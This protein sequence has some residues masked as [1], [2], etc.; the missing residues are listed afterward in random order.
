[1]VSPADRG[2]AATPASVAAVGANAE[3]HCASVRKSR[4]SG[5]PGVEMASTSC[6]AAASL[7]TPSTTW[8]STACELG[9]APRSVAVVAQAGRLPATEVLPLTPAALTW[10]LSV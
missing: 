9:S 5:L 8:K 3:S 6:S 1:M 10:L 4:Y 2:H 7:R